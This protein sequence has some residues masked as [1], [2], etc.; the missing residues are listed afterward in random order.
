[1]TSILFGAKSSP[2]I[3]LFIKNK[4]ASLFLSKYPAAA[5]SIIENSYMDDYLESCETEEEASSSTG[6]QN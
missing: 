2:C 6:N 3:A 4:N 1:M 5:K